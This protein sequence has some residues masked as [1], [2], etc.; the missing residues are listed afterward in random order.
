MSY[1]KKYFERYARLSLQYLP[2]LDYQKFNCDDN[3][4]LQNETDSIGIE[5]TRLILPQ[6]A[7]Y[8]SIINRIMGKGLKYDD[9]KNDERIKPPRFKGKIHNINGIITS[10]YGKGLTNTDSYVTECIECIK[11]KCQKMKKYKKFDKKGLYIFMETAIGTEYL[12]KVYQQI[13][14][15]DNGFDFYLFNFIDTLYLYNHRKQT[16]YYQVTN[17]KDLKKMALENEKAQLH[18]SK[19]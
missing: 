18:N 4:D 11:K 6:K 16:F 8:E 2:F 3:P 10:Y 17:L 19:I 5:V 12:T 13:D 7:E 14:K 1:T 15:I 9:I